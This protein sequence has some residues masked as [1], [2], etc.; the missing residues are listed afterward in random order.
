MEVSD[1]E[2]SWKIELK[3]RKVSTKLASGHKGKKQF[4][5]YICNCKFAQK[6]HLN[7]HVATVHVKKRKK[8]Q[9]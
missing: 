7:H 5:C 1:E 6:V 9:L 4:K 8:N 3:E 2:N